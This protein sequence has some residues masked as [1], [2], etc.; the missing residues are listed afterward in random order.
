MA[1]SEFRIGMVLYGG[2]SLAVYIYG[3]VVEAQRLLRAADELERAEDSDAEPRLSPYAWALRQGGFSRATVDIL[4]GTSAGGINGILLAKA[5]ARG[6]DLASVKDVWL[7]HGDIEQLLQPPSA[8][9]PRSLLQSRMFEKHLNK[10][11]RDLDR[12]SSA[13]APPPVLDLFVSSTHLQGGERIFVDSLGAELQTR[14]HRY[15]FRRKLRTPQKGPDGEPQS[16]AVDQFERNEPLVKLARATSAFPFAFEPVKIETK[17][18][19][20]K[21]REAP[22]WFADGGILNNKPFSEA[23]ETIVNRSS[24]RPVRRW[25]FSIDPDPLPAEEDDG[26]MPS[27]DRTVLR[28]IATIPRYQSI[29]RDLLV[30]D[31]HNEKVAAAEQTVFELEAALEGRSAPRDLGPGIDAAYE[32]MRRQAWGVE[33]ADRLL[34]VTRVSS[35]PGLDS[36]GVHAAYRFVAEELLPDGSADGALHRRR[37]YY[38]IKLIGMSVEASGD[39]EAAKGA[40]WEEYE[41]LSSLLWE[42]L[43]SQPLVLDPRDQTGSAVE[44][45]RPRVLAALEALPEAL[46]RSRGRLRERLG[47]ITVYIV[48]RPGRMEQPQSEARVAR[49]GRVAVRL[50]AV[51]ANFQRRDAT[52]LPA[53]VYGGFHERDRI[54]HA[55]ISPASGRS[56]GVDRADKLAGATLGHFGGFLDRGWRRNDLMWGRLDGAEA[57]VRAVLRD[58]PAAEADGLIEAIQLQIVK[59]ERS[60]LLSGKG[61][62]KDDLRRYSKGDVSEGGLNGRRLVSLGLRTAGIV[63]KML[64]TAADEMKAG[65]PSSRARAFLLRSGAN[66]LGFVLALVSLPATALFA[67]GQLARRGA[68]L[69]ALLPLVWGVATLALGVL[70]VVPFDEVALPALA[71]IAI[72]PVFL[73]LYWG[74]GLLA[75]RLERLFRQIRWAKRR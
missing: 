38:L 31:E 48:P 15:V 4:S 52:L 8:I 61:D 18:E 22:G 59:D 30:L 39:S 33:V 47:R 17:D 26:E 23:V 14:Q 62:W 13:L 65:G 46:E 24:D 53:Y 16:Y 54:E 25:L 32:T 35:P 20:L 41:A 3:V 73:L 60:E 9:D 42:K 67:K 68:V 72:Y 74:L 19:L 64:R 7:D 37:L 50:E 55:Q 40:L 11:L 45:A 58:N 69:L 51:A 75:R 34:G 43:A 27:V 71:A 36:A 63:R 57:L 29:T 1:R 44:Q 28:S 12:P 2:V 10:G 56:T 49:V 21:E 66:V 70:G 5:L 6:S